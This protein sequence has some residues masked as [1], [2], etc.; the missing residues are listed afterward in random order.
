MSSWPYGSG[1]YSNLGVFGAF[2]AYASLNLTVTS[3]QQ[4]FVEPI[5]VPEIQGFLKLPQRSP[6]DPAE[7][8]EL[9]ELISAAR[10]QAEIAQNKDLVVK[11][12]D[13]SLDY[14]PSYR[15]PLGVPL[16][17][18]E[19]LQYMDSNGDVTAMVEDVDYIVDTAKMP[20]ILTPPYNGTWPTFTPWPS[21]AILARFTSGYELADPFWKGPG[22]RV[23]TG[24]KLLISAWFNNK[25]PFEKGANALQE[26]PYTV[27]SCLSHGSLVR[28]R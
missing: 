11:Q 15:I 3:P 25:L 19:L 23:K 1:G 8:A 9:S 5:T 4:V 16:R 7:L 10:E 26:Y 13:L 22:A 14:W 17:S 27:T 21:S 6:V 18:V 24:M 12:Y 2:D 20:G 28:A